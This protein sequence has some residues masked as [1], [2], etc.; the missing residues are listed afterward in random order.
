MKYNLYPLMILLCAINGCGGKGAGADYHEEQH[1]DS[2]ITV[3]IDL[4]APLD[5]TAGLE[6]ESII[7]LD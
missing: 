7:E 5:H 1:V 6:S 3:N 4:S 2:A